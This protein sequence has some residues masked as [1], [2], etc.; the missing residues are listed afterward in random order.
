[1]TSLPVLTIICIFLCRF[2]INFKRY[3]RSAKSFILTP[4]VSL[5]IGN[6]PLENHPSNR[7]PWGQ[8]TASKGRCAAP[9][10]SPPSTHLPCISPGWTCYIAILQKKIS[11]TSQNRIITVVQIDMGIK[12]HLTF[13]YSINLLI[14]KT[15]KQTF[16]QTFLHISEIK[17]F[18]WCK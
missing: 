11:Y 18:Q 17:D 7:H 1:M 12:P 15:N 8:P 2:E 3:I 6:N 16:D 13:S 9:W 4:I 10:C 5:G 14:K